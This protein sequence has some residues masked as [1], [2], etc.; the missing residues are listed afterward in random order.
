MDAVARAIH[1]ALPDPI[2]TEQRLAAVPGI[3]LH[4]AVCKARGGGAV[5]TD[6]RALPLRRRPLP[7]GKKEALVACFRGRSGE[8]LQIA[9]RA[10]GR[11]ITPAHDADLHVFTIC[12][13]AFPIVEIVRT[14]LPL[15]LTP[16]LEIQNEKESALPA[17]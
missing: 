7:A 15:H 17:N 3:R 10:A 4:Q 2:E 13:Y 12:I 9:F 16:K 14:R 8:P 6:D 1:I 5:D 11:R